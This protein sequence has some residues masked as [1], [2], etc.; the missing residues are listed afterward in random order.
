ML[1]NWLTKHHQSTLIDR[2]LQSPAPVTVDD[3]LVDTFEHLDLQISTIYDAQPIELHQTIIDEGRYVIE[4]ISS[5]FSTLTDAQTYLTVV[6]KRSH[7]FFTTTW[8]PT[9]PSSLV[10]DFVTTSPGPLAIVAGVH[11]NSTSFIVSDTLRL[12]IKPYVEDVLR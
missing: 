9:Q 7:H 3:E 12:E 6:M 11:T 1:Q 2:G 8:Q 10:A 4:H 5:T